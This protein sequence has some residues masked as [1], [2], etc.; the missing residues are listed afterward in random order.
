MTAMPGTPTCPRHA[1][2]LS[3]GPV[4]WHCPAGHRYGHRVQAADLSRERTSAP[5]RPHTR[6]TT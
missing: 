1:A 3:G 5:T 4:V 2:E 6:R